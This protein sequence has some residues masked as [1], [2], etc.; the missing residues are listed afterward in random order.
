MGHL[1]SRHC[2]CCYYGDGDDVGS[3]E[4]EYE[5]YGSDD[6]YNRKYGY[7]KK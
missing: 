3:D 6:Y 4:H 5:F 2:D 7:D 1:D